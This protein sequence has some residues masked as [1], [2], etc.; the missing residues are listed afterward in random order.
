MNTK[1]TLVHQPCSGCGYKRRVE[2]HS[3]CWHCN[4]Q[5][6]YGDVANFDDLPPDVRETARR[7]ERRANERLDN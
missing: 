5:R 7:M 6:L 4:Q 2:G 1:R 3:L